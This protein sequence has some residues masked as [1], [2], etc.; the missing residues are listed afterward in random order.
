MRHA[1]PKPTPARTTRGTPLAHGARIAQNGHKVFA[2]SM[3][4]EYRY[5][6]EWVERAPMH[7][8]PFGLAGP[9]GLP[10]FVDPYGHRVRRLRHGARAAAAGA[11]AYLALLALGLAGP[12]TSP[13]S[14]FPGAGAKAGE[15][16][17]EAVHAGS[18]PASADQVRGAVAAVTAAL[19]GSLPAS[20]PGTAGT[21][22]AAAG[23]A[24]ATVASPGSV[25]DASP[26]STPRAAPADRQVQLREPEVLRVVVV[27]KLGLHVAAPAAFG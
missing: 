13:F 5:L 2:S 1:P 16:G 15:S 23:T 24:P 10:V 6:M 19:R 26:A 7:G 12:A 8:A 25:P 21:D 22:P 3:A 18:G 27:R 20:A 11:A 14:L 4:R 9:G 17:T